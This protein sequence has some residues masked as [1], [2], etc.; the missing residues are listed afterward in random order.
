MCGP[1]RQQKA[2]SCGCSKTVNYPAKRNES[3]QTV[4]H[5][6]LEV[7]DNHIHNRHRHQKIVNQHNH[8]HNKYSTQNNTFEYNY[9]PKYE[10][11]PG[12]CK[13]VDVCEE[14]QPCGCDQ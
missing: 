6:H 12:T 11:I 4:N 5:N 8:H 14:P 10:T 9:A 13:S 1:C 3:N 7:E 2:P